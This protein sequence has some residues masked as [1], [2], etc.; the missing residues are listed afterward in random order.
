MKKLFFFIFIGAVTSLVAQNPLFIP[1]TITSTTINL[2]LDTG[3]TQF[4]PG[5]DTKT[6][7]ANGTLLGPTIIMD[8]NSFVDITVDNQLSDTTTMH[9][10]GMHVS[11]ENDG[12]PHTK[13]APGESWNP[14]FTVMDNA[15]TFWY[16]PH[17]HHKTDKHVS[18]GIAGMLLVRDTEEANLNIPLTYGIDE[19]PIIFQTKG[20]DSLNQ[21]EVHTE[22]DTMAMING[23]V[24]AAVDFPAQVVRLRVLNGASQ[25]IM[26]FGFSD[27]RNFNIIGTDGGLLPA[28][29]NKTRC[30][31]AP[32]QRADIL[33]DL[34]AS[35]GQDFKLMSFGSELPNGHY[36]ATT[37]GMQV[38]QLIDGYPNNPLNGSDIELLD[39]NVVAQTAN[40]I[41]TVPATLA[42]LI[43][44]DENTATVTR[45]ITFT[46]SPTAT[47]LS[48]PFLMNGETF[49]HHH[50]NDTV[51]LGATEIWSLTNQ[52]GI[53]H[54][55]H[56]H[57]VQFQILTMNGQSPPAELAGWNDVV[58]V[59][60]NFSNVRFIAKFEDFAS[61]TVPYM[62]HCH[63]LPHEDMGMMG[64]FIVVQAVGIDEA[65]DTFKKVSIYPNPTEGDVSIEGLENVKTINVFSI[66]G[67]LLLT[68]NVNQTTTSKIKMP[69]AKGTYLLELI[70]KT[71]EKA[72]QKIIHY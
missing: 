70:S 68:E 40:P 48:G 69:K 67:K 41:L 52:T 38:W 25:R 21:I 7:G 46:V 5:R 6:M 23:T 20:L 29:V 43:P 35:L 17:L 10:H 47:D 19:F 15:G 9:W 31:L 49:I 34:S 72:T 42:T 14:Q 18:K 3:T 27:N 44:L 54:P 53:A 33:V 65:S 64:Q 58:L 66:E 30:R 55:F 57:D 71:G 56:I 61:D 2:V 12:G 1:P 39:I 16:H 51:Q 63:M 60:G 50:V 37:P 8:K 36:G 24:N 59:K 13:I 11:P 32:G 4:Y 26:E 22:M 45:E 28:P 62:Y